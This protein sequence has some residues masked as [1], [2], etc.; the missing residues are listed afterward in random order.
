[1]EQS[2]KQSHFLQ[3]KSVFILRREEVVA[4]KINK[5]SSWVNVN[6]LRS[7]R[8]PWAIESFIPLLLILNHTAYSSLYVVL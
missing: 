2:E 5:E 1:M 7:R 3:I 6:I 4:K 8:K